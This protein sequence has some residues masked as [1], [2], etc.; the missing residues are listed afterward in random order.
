LA[1]GNVPSVPAYRVRI[2]GHRIQTPDHWV[3]LDRDRVT[4]DGKPVRA[5][6]FF[7]IT[8]TEGRNRQVRRMVGAAGSRVLKLVRTA[9]GGVRIGELRIGQFRELTA[10]EV[11]TLVSNRPAPRGRLVSDSGV[12]MRD[13]Q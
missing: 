10:E 2:N 12:R 7:E 5:S 13:P 3:D 8:I 11:R 6:P 1:L 4:L 9:I